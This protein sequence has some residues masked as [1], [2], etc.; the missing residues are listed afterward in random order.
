MKST[1]LSLF[2]ASALVLPAHADEIDVVGSDLLQGAV[3]EPLKAFA[4]SKDLDVVI[5]LYGSIPAMSMLRNDEAQLALIARPDDGTKFKIDGYDA[6]PFAYQI[7]VVVVNTDNPITELSLK[8]LVGIFGTSSDQY[9]GR[10]GDLGLGGNISKRSIQPMIVEIPDSVTREL[11][12]SKVLDRG[13][14]K[15]N[16]LTIENFEKSPELMVSDTGAI[17]IFPYVPS[18]S[19]LR[20]VSISSGEPGAFAYGPSRENV[21][22]GSY[23]LRLPFYLVFK[24]ENKA[25]LR[26]ILRFML[27]EETSKSLADNGFVPLSE[28]VRKRTNLEL[29]IGS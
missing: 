15:S 18:Q 10:W 19:S 13:A 25:E 6:I 29:D 4:E 27:S 28:N 20:A 12:K 24:K 7:A 3:A 2:A 1:L 17:G 8:Q 22:D 9:Y 21:Y 11:F 26:E 23:V 16:T 5:D 14:F